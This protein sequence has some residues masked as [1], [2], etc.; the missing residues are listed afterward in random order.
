MA[1]QMKQFL[2]ATGKLF[3]NNALK[4]KVVSVFTSTNTQHGGQESTILSFHICMLHHGCIIAGLP[5]DCK[6]QF[7][8]SEAHGLSPY[9]ASTLAGP[10]G[11]RT[12]TKGELE[13]AAYQGERTAQL[14]ADLLAGKQAR[15]AK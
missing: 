7:D 11:S 1:G 10:D 9:G 15:T 12:P 4:D 5:Y 3:A 2:D 13:G 8:M 6:Y 14:A